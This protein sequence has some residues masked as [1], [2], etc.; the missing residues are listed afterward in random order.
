MFMRMHRKRAHLIHIVVEFHS[1]DWQGSALPGPGIEAIEQP[2]AAVLLDDGLGDYLGSR[3]VDARCGYELDYVVEPQRVVAAV[4][5][6]RG[7]LKKLG[8]PQDT[9]VRVLGKQAAEYPVY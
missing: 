9:I 3:W 8:A 7:E 6:L 4:G 2:L 5:A 1:N